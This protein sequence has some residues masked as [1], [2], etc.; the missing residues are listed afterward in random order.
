M[1]SPHLAEFLADFKPKTHA[2]V[3]YNTPEKKHDVLLTHMKYGAEKDQGLAY[4]CSDQTPLQVEGEMKKFGIDVERLRA[5]HRLA[6]NNYDR[7]YIVDGKVDIPKIMTSF[8]DLSTK[9]RAMGLNG[10]RASAEMSCFIKERKMNE[11][12]MYE[13]AMHRKL[14]F[15]AEGICGYNI[16]EL[17]ESGHLK[18]IMQ[19]LRAHDPVIMAG[20]NDSLILQ[21]EKVEP[22]DLEEALKI[23]F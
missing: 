23:K 17:C 18:A 21:P 19:L 7:V 11:L 12:I 15:E 14:R 6:I 8:S 13:Y 20:P 22:K 4:V 1:L 3:F 9:Y 2:I 10:L 16:L 5:Q